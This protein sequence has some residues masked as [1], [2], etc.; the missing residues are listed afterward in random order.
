MATQSVKISRDLGVYA[1]YNHLNQEGGFTVDPTTLEH[2]SFDTGFFVSVKGFE[3]KVNS[4][5]VNF[6]VFKATL[7]SY[8][9][10][11]AKLGY[12]FGAWVENSHIFFD[13]SIHVENKEDAIKT[14][15]ANAQLAIWDVANSQAIS[16]E[17]L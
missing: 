7:D 1:L 8:C 10:L 12:Y 16:L 4:S 2:V 11:A 15:V 3:Y 17:V 5:L 13:L 6:E 14:G 9:R